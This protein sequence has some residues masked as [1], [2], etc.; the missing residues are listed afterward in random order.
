LVRLVGALGWCAWLVRL[1]GALGWCAWLVRLV[2][3]WHLLVGAVGVQASA[4]LEGKC[5]LGG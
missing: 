4:A 1:V 5:G 2:G 3:A